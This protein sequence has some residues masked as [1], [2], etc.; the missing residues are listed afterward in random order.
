MQPDVLVE[1]F[2]DAG[3]QID[4][5]HVCGRLGG[6]LD[7]ALDLA[8]LV[9][10]LIDRPA[11]AGAEL[12]HQAGQLAADG[13]EN[14]A[15]LPHARD[16]HLRSRAA[17]E[18]SL[19]DRLWI[20]LHRQ[21]TGPL[22][23]AGRRR[24][25]DPRDRVRVRAAIALTAVA[26]ARVRIF[27]RELQRRQQRLLPDAPRDVLIDRRA[28]DGR[29]GTG[30]LPRLDAGEVRGRDPVI[31]SGRALWRLRRLRPQTAQ[32]DGVLPDSFE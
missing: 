8:N 15:V 12:L 30:G 27:D 16:A 26:R 22:N 7:A 25:A 1:R 24:Q 14:A 5:R 31:G 20:E 18:E 2:R 4:L 9:G 19:E 29:V 10:V 23:F 32:D 13:I 17:A 3:R 11:V 6:E 28:A 21:R